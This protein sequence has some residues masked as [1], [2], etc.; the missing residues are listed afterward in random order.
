M[1]NLYISGGSGAVGIRFIKEALSNYVEISS[2]TLIYSSNV[3][4]E[5]LFYEFQNFHNVHYMSIHNLIFLKN[6]LINVFINFAFVSNG[7]P[8]SRI[9]KNYV[10]VERLA[11]FA[12]CNN[13]DHFVEISSQSVFG[14]S[15][16]NDVHV[17]EKHSFFCEEY[18]LTKQMGE[19]AVKNVLNNSNCSYSIVRLG[20]VL[21]RNS[22][23]FMQRVFNITFSEHKDILSHDGYLNGT[24][25]PNTLAGIRYLINNFGNLPLNSIYHFSEVG[26][27]RWSFIHQIL[28]KD[29]DQFAF[30]NIEDNSIKSNFYFHFLIKFLKS[31]FSSLILRIFAV[32]IP[33]F[34]DNKIEKIYKKNRIS[35]FA[36]KSNF[37]Q[38][39]LNSFSEKYRFLPYF[40]KGFRFEVTPI[41][42]ENYLSGIFRDQIPFD[43]ND[44]KK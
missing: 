4:K 35:S 33:S 13:F 22:G 43:K 27:F 25:L 19:N 2:F 15:F 8:W 7:T 28:K 30:S 5:R 38:S 9:K 20:N 21:F 42:F 12:K 34:L 10:L 32:I 44:F 24:L 6:E 11:R 16:S 36:S 37:D 14:F 23:P 18:G 3:G 29:F 39:V 40:P 17:N 26:H 41:E 1:I 31:R